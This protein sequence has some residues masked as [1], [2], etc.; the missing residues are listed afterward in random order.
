MGRFSLR[1]LCSFVV[2]CGVY[3]GGIPHLCFVRL[4][5]HGPDDAVAFAS[6]AV[7]AWLLLAA[8]Y[9][10]WRHLTPL[11]IHCLGV[12]LSVPMLN[13]L[14]LQVEMRHVHVAFA[15]LAPGCVAATLISFPV[16]LV[17]LVLS[18]ATDR[19]IEPLRNRLV[20]VVR[21]NLRQEFDRFAVLNEEESRF[22]TR[23]V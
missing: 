17:L 23:D 14:D 19:R 15:T 16:S 21:P 1:Q 11:A 18:A 2:A 12:A 13:S 20:R 3:V 4:R 8:V 6:E 9:V 22:L 7:L 10:Y 5:G